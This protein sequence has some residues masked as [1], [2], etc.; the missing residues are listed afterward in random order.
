MATTIIAIYRPPD[1][2][3]M[4][5]FA[6]GAGGR[7][8]NTGEADLRFSRPVQWRSGPAPFGAQRQ[9]AAATSALMVLERNCYV[10]G[11][12][13]MVLRAQSDHSSA[14]LNT[15]GKPTPLHG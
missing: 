2:A 7:A 8:A 6:E 12:S 3:R 11:H 14:R 1:S 10:D 9:C 13:H 4:A 15:Q 5:H